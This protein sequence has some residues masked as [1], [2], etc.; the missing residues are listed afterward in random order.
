MAAQLQKTTITRWKGV[1]RAAEEIGCSKAHLYY[2]LNG[3]RYPGR[4]MAR[5]LARMGVRIDELG[6]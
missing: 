5:K 1:K 4:E 3:K 2:V 6:K